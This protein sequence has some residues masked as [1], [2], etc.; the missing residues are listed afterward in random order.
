M[1][2]VVG[3]LDQKKNAQQGK[4]SKGDKMDRAV[5][6][7]PLIEHAEMPAVILGTDME[8]GRPVGE[9]GPDVE[10]KTDDRHNGAD[11]TG[12][13]GQL[14]KEIRCGGFVHNRFFGA[15]R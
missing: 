7:L 5:A 12:G 8:I 15:M 14:D 10:E 3:K 11:Q 6:F 2:Q 1:I 4:K 9:P 13:D